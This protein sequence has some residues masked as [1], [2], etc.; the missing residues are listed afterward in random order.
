[1]ADDSDE[2]PKVEK[3]QHAYASYKLSDDEWEIIQLIH[4]VLKIRY[5]LYLIVL[6]LKC[7]RRRQMISNRSS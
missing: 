2:V 6:K 4:D 3:G 1:M 7:S 5:S